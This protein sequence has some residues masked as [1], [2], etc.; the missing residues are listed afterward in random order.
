MRSIYHQLKSEKPTGKQSTRWLQ[1]CQFIEGDILDDAH[2]CGKKVVPGH[3]YCEEHLKLCTRPLLGSASRSREFLRGLASELGSTDM[4][5]QA[6]E[7]QPEHV[8]ELME[9][10]DVKEGFYYG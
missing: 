4:L 2:K 1:Q 5:K 10:E 6:A 3:A 8:T 9:G 7:Q